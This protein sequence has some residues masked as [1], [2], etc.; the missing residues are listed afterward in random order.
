M[1]QGASEVAREAYLRLFLMGAPKVGKT[2]TVVCTSEPGVLLINCD[3]RGAIR[4]AVEHWTRKDGSLGATVGDEFDVE[5]VHNLLDMERAIGT[6]K[7]GVKA[8]KYRTIVIDP[9]TT[10]AGNIEQELADWSNTGKGPDG[11]RFWPEYAKRLQNTVSRLFRLKA[12][13]IVTAH[14]L[15]TGGEVIEGQAAKVGPGIAPLLGGKAR[16]IIPAMFQDV[17]FMEKNGPKRVFT[18]SIEGVWGPGCRSMGDD[19]KQVPANVLI[20]MKQMGIK[21]I[22]GGVAKKTA[23]KLETTEP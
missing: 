21:R 3:D 20:L 17:V 5:L 9:I 16:S 18:T 2:R 11:R 22:G 4:P 1:P 13:V 12:H 15:E 14:Y 23:P 19:V 7:A 8:G 6:A 10:Y